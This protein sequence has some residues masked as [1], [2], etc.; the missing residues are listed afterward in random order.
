M[1][2]VLGRRRYDCAVMVGVTARYTPPRGLIRGRTNEGREEMNETMERERCS[3]LD[4]VL[5]GLQYIIMELRVYWLS[6]RDTT[7]RRGGA[8]P[9]LQLTISKLNYLLWLEKRMEYK[10][11]HM[12]PR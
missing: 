6:I 4:D 3:S 11:E 1:K 10:L 9:N 5:Y 2:H 7:T 8:S 12:M